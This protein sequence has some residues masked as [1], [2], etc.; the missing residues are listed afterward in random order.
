MTF[1]RRHTEGLKQWRY[2]YS[3][4]RNVPP[5]NCR[6]L[7]AA[8]GHDC[9]HSRTFL[10]WCRNFA[11]SAAKCFIIVSWRSTSSRVV[12]VGDVI[13]ENCFLAVLRSLSP[14]RRH[15]LTLQCPGWGG[16][17]NELCG[18]CSSHCSDSPTAQLTSSVLFRHCFLLHW[19]LWERFFFTSI[20][21]ECTKFSAAQTF[22]LRSV[23]CN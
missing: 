20:H 13:E 6:P 4:C 15:W 16:Q 11:L 9:G 3:E 17:S 18:R 19:F 1:S 21:H 5:P 8:P 7:T 2:L 10:S 14:R 22:S 23:S 12:C